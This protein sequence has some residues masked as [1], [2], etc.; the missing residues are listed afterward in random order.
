MNVNYK[1]L[2]EEYAEDLEREVIALLEQGW[3]TCG[4]VSFCGWQERFENERKGYTEER[5]QYRIAQAMTK[6]GFVPT[7]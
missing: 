4:G 2:V 7:K 1:I 3:A 5:T 6:E